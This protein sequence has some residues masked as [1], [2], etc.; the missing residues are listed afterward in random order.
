MNR[1]PPKVLRDIVSIMLSRIFYVVLK[2]MIESLSLKIFK[3]V[4]GLSFST[5]F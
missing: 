3:N 4:L 2:K 1:K 5:Q